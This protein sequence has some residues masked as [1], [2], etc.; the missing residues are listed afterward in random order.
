MQKI[1][2]LNNAQEQTMTTEL[3]IIIPA[4]NEADYIESLIDSIRNSVKNIQFEIIVIDNGSTDNTAQI[5]NDAGATVYSTS[6]NTVSKARN[7]GLNKANA[8]ILAFLDADVRITKKWGEEIV[9]II[10][11]LRNEHILTGARYLIPENPGWI[12]KHWFEPLSKKDVSYINGGNLILSKNTYEIIGGFNDDLITAEDYEFSMR[13]LSK[14]VVI[15][16]NTN[17]EAIHDG[18]PKNL[19]NFCKREFWHGK[20]DCQSIALLLKSKVSMAA[21]IFGFLHILFIMCL[22]FQKTTY[23]TIFLTAIFVLTVFMSLKIFNSG[24]IKNVL[25]NIPM[26]YLY[27]ISRFFSFIA[28][29]TGNH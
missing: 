8:D 1:K 27:L 20:G 15:K 7:T 21:I 10:P 4:Y 9:K 12:E 25:L 29:I 19:Y 24:N 26:C 23:S 11:E 5:A 18:Y 14:G 6:R 3:S 22:I 28:V 17:L 13:A 16:N 2:I